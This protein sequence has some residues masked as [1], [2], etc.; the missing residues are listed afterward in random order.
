M[1]DT[2]PLLAEDLSMWMGERLPIV[3][4]LMGSGKGPG[5]ERLLLVLVRGGFWMPC[6]RCPRGKRRLAALGPMW[7]VRL[8]KCGVFVDVDQPLRDGRVLLGVSRRR[9]RPGWRFR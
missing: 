2:L 6:G 7:K 3:V 1:V 5:L 8:H 4:L 9:D